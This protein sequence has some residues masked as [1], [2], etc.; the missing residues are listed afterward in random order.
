VVKLMLGDVL[1]ELKAVRLSFAN[2]PMSASPH[3]LAE[4]K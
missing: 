2:V 3:R 4:V 1:K